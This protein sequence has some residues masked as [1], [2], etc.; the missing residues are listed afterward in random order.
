MKKRNK[1]NPD[2]EAMRKNMQ[3]AMYSQTSQEKRAEA[4]TTSSLV[5]TRV[6]TEQ[7]VQVIRVR[8]KGDNGDGNVF[9]VKFESDNGKRPNSPTPKCRGC[10][11][12]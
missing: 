11:I 6:M 9:D 2:L 3:K 10:N 12:M 5:R 7:T 8:K 4:Y 1:V